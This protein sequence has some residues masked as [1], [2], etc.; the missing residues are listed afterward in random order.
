MCSLETEF[1]ERGLAGLDA[2]TNIRFWAHLVHIGHGL[3]YVQ[4]SMCSC[5][6]KQYQRDCYIPWW[7]LA[8]P[9]WLLVVTPKTYHL[10]LIELSMGHLE[11]K[12]S[13]FYFNFNAESDRLDLVKTCFEKASSKRPIISEYAWSTAVPYIR[14]EACCQGTQ[15]K[16]ESTKWIEC[17]N[18]N[19][20]PSA[21]LKKDPKPRAKLAWKMQKKC[22]YIS[23]NA[24][25]LSCSVHSHACLLFMTEWGSEK[26]W[27]ML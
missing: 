2:Q 14:S 1:H 26:C 4:H 5:L 22:R 3:F 23:I 16:I 25:N 6:V 10:K 21:S 24:W 8:Y 20:A 17:V 18:S 9:I 19:V 27:V 11:T 13:S 15:H 7:I 12:S